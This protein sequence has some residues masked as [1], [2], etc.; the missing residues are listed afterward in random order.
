MESYVVLEEPISESSEYFSLEESTCEGKGKEKLDL[1]DKSHK[2]ETSIENEEISSSDETISPKNGQC[3]HQYTKGINKGKYCLK[4]TIPGK[5]Y[6]NR[7]LSKKYISDGFTLPENCQI[8]PLINQCMYK[9]IR[10]PNKG[11]Y[12]CRPI[13][14]GF[15]YC[16]DC[17]KK[18]SGNNYQDSPNK[19]I[20]MYTR[21]LHKGE[22]CHKPTVTGQRYCT[23]CIRSKSSKCIYR[24]I[25]GPNKGKRCLK[26]T[27][28][29]SRYCL[30]CLRKKSIIKL[31]E[32]FNNRCM[33]TFIRGPHKGKKCFK[34]TIEGQKYCNECNKKK[35]IGV[36]RIEIN[37]RC[38]YHYIRGP[39]KNKQCL[40]PCIEGLKYCNI[41]SKKKNVIKMLSS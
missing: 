22:F 13:V 16:K 25:R 20:H 6:C 33:Y 11:K 41:C 7:C 9:F 40:K 3:E 5:K 21:G 38:I 29:G 34:P 36:N 14:K 23:R 24:F 17:L 18:K 35:L 27:V 1:V 26:S 8:A 30:N 4:S 39:H 28:R 31:H 15:N 2:H 10:G 32:E 37:N 19:C 12:C